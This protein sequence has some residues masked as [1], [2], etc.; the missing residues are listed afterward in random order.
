MGILSGATRL[1]VDVRQ[2]VRTPV[3]SASPL[4]RGPSALTPPVPVEDLVKGG[5]RGESQRTQIMAYSIL[6]RGSPPSCGE[7]HEGGVLAHDHHS[8]DRCPDC[9]LI[10]AEARRLQIREA[11]NSD[12]PPK[13]LVT[14]W[15]GYIAG[16]ETIVDQG[17]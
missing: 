11:E 8:T 5:N 13:C 14:I 1:L 9:C 7:R 15:A 17:F 6:M 12:S 2:T 16:V 3:T 4:G 10:G